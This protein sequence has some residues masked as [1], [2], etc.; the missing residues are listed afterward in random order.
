MTKL[1]LSQELALHQEAL[2]GYRVLKVKTELTMRAYK[3]MIRE[4]KEGKTP[5]S[6]EAL[7]GIEALLVEVEEI[8]ENVLYQI[9][10]NENILKHNTL[11][12]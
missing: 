7:A 9:E 5:L 8:Y 2:N 3:K 4:T 1:S 6:A 11:A 10:K 12:N